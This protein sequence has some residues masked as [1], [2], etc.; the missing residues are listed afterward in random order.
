M[1]NH[2]EREYNI[3]KLQFQKTAENLHENNVLIPNEIDELK[4]EIRRYK[5]EKG[6]L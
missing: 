6:T 5:Q 4:S 3:L 2:W 1:N